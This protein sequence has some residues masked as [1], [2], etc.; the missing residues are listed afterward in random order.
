[1]Q[2]TVKRKLKQ[3]LLKE[4]TKISCYE[5]DSERRFDSTREVNQLVES[6]IPEPSE[7]EGSSPVA[8]WTRVS[9]KNREK[10]NLISV[11]PGW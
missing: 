4:D 7:Q 5:R 8:V 6:S 2:P 9:K 10:M 1:M 3:T 11:S